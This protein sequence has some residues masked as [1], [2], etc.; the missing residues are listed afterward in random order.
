MWKISSTTFYVLSVHWTL[1]AKQHAARN[2][3]RNWLLCT[4]RTS[5]ARY[6]LRSSLYSGLYLLLFQLRPFIPLHYVLVSECVCVRECV[7]SICRRSSFRFRYAAE[8]GRESVAESMNDWVSE[9]MNGI[10]LCRCEFCL[11]L[12]FA[13]TYRY[14]LLLFLLTWL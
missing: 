14:L 4:T 10:Y 3:N 1:I 6:K 2:G 8:T 7:L 13:Q 5:R 9:W 11:F 12:L